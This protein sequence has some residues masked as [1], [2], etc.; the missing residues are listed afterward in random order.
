MRMRPIFFAKWAPALLMA[1]ALPASLLAA[2]PS[3]IL[4]SSGDAWEAPPAGYQDAID[5]GIRSFPF[6]EALESYRT[7]L[8][9]GE[10]AVGLLQQRS[11]LPLDGAGDAAARRI[12]S[13]AVEQMEARRRRALSAGDGSWTAVDDI[14]LRR[15]RTVPDGAVSPYGRPYLVR[16]FAWS[17]RPTALTVSVCG[18][19]VRTIVA[20]SEM[21]APMPERAAAIV[22]LEQPPTDSFAQWTERAVPLPNL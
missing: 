3:L 2:T 5:R 22:F 9:A 1:A 19:Y 13:D 8:V 17:D 20:S 12:L 14:E 4:G 21:P 15:V 11:F 18:G 10:T 16:A 6:C 7:E